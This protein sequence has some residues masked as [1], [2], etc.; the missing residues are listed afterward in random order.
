MSF[1]RF[2]PEQDQEYQAIQASGIERTRRQRELSKVNEELAQQK[3]LDLANKQKSDYQ[4][5][6]KS[7]EEES[8]A[9]ADQKALDKLNRQKANYKSG[10]VDP[11]DAEDEAQSRL[12]EQDKNKTDFQRYTEK[13]GYDLDNQSKAWR[14]ASELKQSDANQSN[15]AQKDRLV[16][17]IGGQK[18]QQQVAINQANKLRSDDNLRAINGFKGN[19]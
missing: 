18:D 3:A 13:S 8:K 5:G 12:I 10:T 7:F 6:V 15:I 11:K 17:Q 2:T 4:S 14:L 19:I 1:S 9:F 16:T